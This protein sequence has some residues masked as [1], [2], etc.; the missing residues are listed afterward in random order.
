MNQRSS[1]LTGITMIAVLALAPA[2]AFSQATSTA[3]PAGQKPPPPK[4]VAAKPSAPSPALRTPSKLKETAP[5]TF[6]V[7]FD[8]TAG[9][10]V[11]EVHR[12]WAPKGADRFYNLVK[13]GYYDNGRFFRVIPGFMVQFGIH[14]DPK[15]QGGWRD[16]NIPDDPVTQSNKRGFIT[17][18]TAGPNSRTTQVFINFRDNGPLDE[19]GF[20]PFGQ[21]ISGMESVD[22]INA[23]HGESP[24]QHLIQSQGD[25]YLTKEFPKLDYVR[26]ATIA[27]GPPPPKK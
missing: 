24:Q 12:A 7:N 21:V 20:A 2:P 6:T 19:R 26:K 22:K 9:P 27:K 3:K 10:F 16:A 13:H 11:V 8:T 17:F 5:A 25:A 14:G 4:P 15:I 1:F 18:A 23:Q